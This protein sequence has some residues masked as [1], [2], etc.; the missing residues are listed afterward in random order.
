LAR[1]VSDTLAKTLLTG[2]KTIVNLLFATLHVLVQNIFSKG[3][4]IHDS[5]L[6]QP[7]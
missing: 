1:K 4:E 7:E 5:A 3:N 6:Q 2:T